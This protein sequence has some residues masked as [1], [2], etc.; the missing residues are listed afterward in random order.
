M[1]AS[2][3]QK[4]IVSSFTDFV[5]CISVPVQSKKKKQRQYFKPGCKTCI[6]IIRPF[7]MDYA[8]NLFFFS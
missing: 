1:L 8:I 3:L 5:L 2:N 4:L 7:S 6:A